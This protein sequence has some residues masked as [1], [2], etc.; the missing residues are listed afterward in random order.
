MATVVLGVVGN[1]IFPGVG[2]AIGAGVGAVIDSLVVSAISRSLAPD[3]Q[4]PDI[5][6]H[7]T[8]D[9]GAPA[10][11]V[12]GTSIRVPGQI[13]Y[14]SALKEVGV[15][16]SEKGKSDQIVVYNYFYNVG[17]AFARVK[18]DPEPITKIWAS[19]ELIYQREGIFNIDLDGGYAMIGDQEWHVWNGGGNITGAD[20]TYCKPSFHPNKRRANE[21]L[22]IRFSAPVGGNLEKEILGLVNQIAYTPVTISNCQVGA[23]NG[24]YT[25]INVFD[26]GVVGLDRVFEMDFIRCVYQY[27]TPGD[28][29]A[30]S[31]SP[32][33]VPVVDESSNSHV[34]TLDFTVSG[35]S[36]YFVTPLSQYPGSQT[37]M[38]DPIIQSDP[39][40]DNTLVPAFRGTTY[41][42]LQTF[43]ATKW[44]GTL[45]QF[46]AEI[47][48][49]TFGS[50]L[51]NTIEALILRAE[52]T[53]PFAIDLTG[54]A[55]G[56][57]INGLFVM[58][59]Q[60]PINMLRQL[61]TLY[62]VEAQEDLSLVPGALPVSKLKF[63]LADDLADT[64]NNVFVDYSLTS[65]R[66]EGNEGR[67]HA[68]I[69]RSTKDDLPQ[70]F[71]LDFIDPDRE[72]QP[73]TT[74]YAIK[75]APIRNTQKLSTSVTLT[76]AEADVIA[77]T[78]LWKAISRND[79]IA[80]SLPPSELLAIE[81]DRIFLQNTATGSLLCRVTRR[82]R[83]ENGLIEIEAELDDE[84]TYDQNEGGGYSANPTPGVTVPPMGQ[85]GVMDIAPL[86][87]AEA[88]MF[89]LQVLLRQGASSSVTMNLYLSK[90]E[91]TWTN[92][93]NFTQ[94]AISGLT[95]DALPDAD[96]H[97]RDVLNKVT[98]R[99]DNETALDN[100]TDEQA[101]DGQ[102][103]M[104]IGGEIIAFETATLIDSRTYELTNLR[105]GRNDSYTFVPIH[106][107]GD[108][109]FMLPPTGS[110]VTF[111]TL[112]PSDFGLEFFLRVAPSGKSVL[113]PSVA[114]TQISTIPQAESLR[115]YSVHGIWSTMKL[116]NTV[117]VF[118]TERT[119]V[120]FR[121]F[122]ALVPPIIETG[123]ACDF[124]A[125][126][127]WEETFQTWGFIRTVKGCRLENQQI[128]FSYTRAQQISDFIDSGLEA[129]LPGF[130]RFI[131]R[132]T[133]DTIG[134]GREREFCVFTTGAQFA[135]D[136]Q[137]A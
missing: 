40:I 89:G 4:P 3:I 41:C 115:P 28:P 109:V 71:E 135:S 6:R 51:A 87:A 114:E 88:Q 43:D 90:D 103:W 34:I 25:V 57:T 79:R 20:T 130:F 37:Q 110:G 8:A 107:I 132:H 50:N 84:L 63:V 22:L 13:I 113:D 76:Q 74:S 86:T 9:E 121:I 82:D 56:P 52:S 96:I 5:L 32:A 72:L 42:V 111:I 33:C 38:P 36:G 54:V 92:P 75:T 122:S 78:L 104:F 134:G 95:L 23:N 39:L 123:G 26:T 94:P 14:L 15:P 80:F 46:E 83:G 112:E 68:Q 27:Q 108:Q 119:R 59:P 125:D 49:R 48:Q 126:I 58:G 61:M 62:D 137:F 129:T 30:P 11:W 85:P 19:G 70:E 44:G 128:A 133:S 101:E 64:A 67:V 106:D 117:C 21:R 35:F 53:N 1:L 31:N 24:I 99:L 81:S 91:I 73:G 98:V 127:Y 66:E 18:C 2:G 93:A 65:A 77:R 16:G 47:R 29:C 100:V 118:C 97:F 136:C 45:P 124:E 60:P 55:G 69:R 131:I 12:Q 105:R 10:P 7:P 102:N 17:I 120:P 116:D